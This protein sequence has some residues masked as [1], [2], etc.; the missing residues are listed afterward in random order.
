M[1][2]QAQTQSAD[3]SWKDFVANIFNMDPQPS[4]T[5]SIEALDE[6]PKDGLR[7]Y[8]GYFIMYGAKKLY[9]KELAN[10]SVDEIDHLKRFLRS[11]GWDV[12]YKVETRDQKLKEDSH[13]VTKVNYF[14]IDFFP[15]KR[16]ELN[17]PNKPDRFA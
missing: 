14:L 8:L 10:L 5:F 15:A 3:F 11:I 9:K 6:I 17:N 2:H 12:D 4:H 1:Q 7:Q 16:D 13:E